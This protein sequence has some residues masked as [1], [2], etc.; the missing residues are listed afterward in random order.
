MNFR[1]FRV[2]VHAFRISADLNSI[3]SSSIKKNMVALTRGS[4]VKPKKRKNR[5]IAKCK[6]SWLTLD[7]S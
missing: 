4:L 3:F 2:T 7:S 1:N 5:K 6:I